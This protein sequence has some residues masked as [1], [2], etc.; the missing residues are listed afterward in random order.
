MEDF[1]DVQI[2]KQTQG[3]ITK[4]HQNLFKSDCLKIMPIMN[5][6]DTSGINF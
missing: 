2:L 3:N 5:V 6:G 1:I 4:P